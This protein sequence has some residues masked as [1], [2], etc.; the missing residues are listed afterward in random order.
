MKFFVAFPNEHPDDRVA[1]M[2]PL[3]TS[4]RQKNWAPAP[5]NQRLIKAENPVR[6]NRVFFRF[7]FIQALPC[8]NIHDC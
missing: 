8:D 1:C 5:K 6:P 2:K 7:A 3:E 4:E